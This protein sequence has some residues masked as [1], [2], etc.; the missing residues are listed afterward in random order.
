MIRKFK[1]KSA[2]LMGV[3]AAMALLLTGVLAAPA[4]S[5]E[6]PDS[7]DVALAAQSHAV[8]T[9]V[10]QTDAV[11][12]EDALA[13]DWD[14]D[15]A[16]LVDVTDEGAVGE[17]ATDEGDVAPTEDVAATATLEE[18]PGITFPAGTTRISGAN[19]YETAA[20]IS[21]FYPEGVDAAFVATVAT[22]PDALSAASAA[23]DMG[24][25]LLLTSKTTFDS[26]DFAVIATGA[27]FPDALAASG[28]AGTEAGPVILVNGRQSSV[29]SEV[30]GELNRLGVTDVLI[31]GGTGVV[32][33]G[34][35]SQLGKQFSGVRQV[36]GSHCLVAVGALP[37]TED[38]GLAQAGVET[39]ASG[40]VR[41]DRV[42]RTT[43]YRIYA[44]GDCTG[45]LPLASVAAEQGRIAMW[46]ALGDSLKPLDTEAV[47]RAV[48]TSP[49]VAAVGISQAAAGEAGVRTRVAQ[50]PLARN[51]RA[52]MQGVTEGFVKI[53]AS[54]SG[55][56]LGGVIV[57][58]QASDLIFPLA[59]AVQSRTT[60]DELAG[61]STIYPS[62]SGTVMEVARMLH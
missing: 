3:P 18:D 20:A 28:V 7:G 40:H 24:A 43:S 29:P 45:V 59:L 51:P 4:Y 31:A 57:G 27:N 19:R 58:P 12:S 13:P 33:K 26:A 36:V 55:V 42:S 56:V 10:V 60:V 44:A 54:R 53:I 16:Q 49:E 32:S 21:S 48:F 62:I 5:T 52:K 8:Q 17:D 50:L 39:T 38:L 11:Q 14:E 46:H 41:V 9:D 47:A 34:I 1:K 30:V 25:P 22:F 15:G 61:A 2:Q 23:A 6:V 35:Q 37:N